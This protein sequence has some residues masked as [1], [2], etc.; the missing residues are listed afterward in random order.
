MSRALW[1]C[2]FGVFLG[3]AV[4]VEPGQGQS[5]A[6]TVVSAS[7]AR[8]L[9]DQYCVGCHS[10]KTKTAGL[11]LD[12]LDITHIGD[13]AEIW[14]KVVR[15]LRAGMMPPSGLRR[16]DPSTYEGLT[17]W[18]ENELDR[19]AAAKPQYLPP[20]LHRLNRTEYAN[21][22][23]DVL[24]L[25]V[26]VSEFL[27]VDDSSYGFDN[28]A[29]SLGISPALVEGYMS[30]SS[31]ISRL[32]VG[33][34][35]SPSQK[36]YVA[37]QD[38]SQES[39]VEGLPF[40]TRGGML[41]NHYFAADGEYVISW[42]PVR[43][44][45]GELY[46]SERKE[47]KLEVLLDGDRVGLFEMAKIPNGTD[48]DKNQVRLKVKAGKHKVGVAFLASTDIPIDDLNQHYLRSV[49]DTNPIPG[50]IFSPQVSQMLIVGPYNATRPK[51]SASRQKIFVCHP[52]TSAEE[53]SCAKQIISKVGTQAYRRPV[54]DTDLENL[55]GLYQK[56]R[57][58]GDF[59]DGIEVAIQYILADPEFLFRSERDP[60]NAKPG[61]PYR[62][63]DLELASRLAFFLWSAPPDTELLTLASQQRLHD[64]KVLEGQTRRMLADAR[65]HEL[66]KNFAGQWLQLRNLPS[67]APITQMFPDFDDNLRQAFRI[68]AEMFFD[69]I[70]RE[71]RSVVDLLNAD[72]TFVNERLARHYGIP[73]VYGSQFRKVQLTADL[74]VRRGLLGKGAIELVTSDPDRTSPVL[75]GKW[76]LMN[77]MG[78][79]PPDP[80][81]NVPQLRESGKMANGQP[82]PLELSMRQRMEEHRQNPVCAS[83]HKM[84]D[85]IGFA[86]EN[87]DAVG[88]WRTLEFGQKL[89]VTADITDGTHVNGPAG[90]RQYFM[91][92]SP[93]F[94]RVV[95]EKLLTYALGRGAEHYDMPAIRSIVHGAAADDY[96]LNALIIGIVKSEPFQ[97]NVRVDDGSRQ[98]ASAP[99][100]RSAEPRL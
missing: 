97:M 99:R 47:E 5:K 7:S 14:E 19:A 73:N 91:R 68:E 87:F 37:P 63:S 70:V 27:P 54:N 46:G 41:V 57:N 74:D 93:Q 64:P 58:R 45:T 61:Q 34:E 32:A 25:D 24:G 42:F 33:H 77:L 96:K 95:T 52:N 84:M 94:V 88:K 16:P 82:V 39:H 3:A 78:I 10:V 71:N 49:L 66:V 51:D 23:R 60:A 9:L 40:G 12:Q 43:G 56:G 85:P 30:A 6:T 28:V 11:T 35:T 72:Y 2:V 48:N 67:T 21:A 59:E 65:S 83:C 1:V 62:I 79:I 18:L 81:P 22:I 80:P 53:I 76:V 13:H 55:L 17:V 4:C 15:K 75:R 8:Q 86:M 44:N 29:S 26:D 38:Y 20:G 98:S 69:S 31:K 89:E 100:K 36:K 50:Y 90:L 92:Y